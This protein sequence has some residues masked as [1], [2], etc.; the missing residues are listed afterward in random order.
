MFFEY[1]LGLNI[2]LFVVLPFFWWYLIPYSFPVLCMWGW[3]MGRLCKYIIYL[4]K[5][6]HG[7]WPNGSLRVTDNLVFLL[8]Q[9]GELNFEVRHVWTI[10]PCNFYL[11]HKIHKTNLQVGL[12]QVVK[13]HVSI[14]RWCYFSYLPA[15]QK[16]GKIHGIFFEPGTSV[17]RW[18][19][20]LMFEWKWK[21]PGHVRGITIGERPIFLQRLWE[22]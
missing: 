19:C 10:W 22:G 7:P 18:G 4:S 3:N 5:L 11:D 6:P 17:V 21:M 14:K 9:A 8:C 16:A 12:C 2:E 15:V 20:R 1:E 13:H